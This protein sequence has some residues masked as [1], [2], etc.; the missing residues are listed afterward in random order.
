MEHKLWFEE[1]NQITR[2]EVVGKI[3]AGEMRELLRKADE[4]YANIAY[5]VLLCDVSRG[6]WPVITRGSRKVLRERGVKIG[7]K[8][9]A[10]LNVPSTMHIVGKMLASIWG[11][12]EG[13]RFFTSEEEAVLWLKETE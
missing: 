11:V 12:L 10:F 9:V 1:K 5:P 8:R 13:T 3:E 2:L 7:L 6:E 4:I